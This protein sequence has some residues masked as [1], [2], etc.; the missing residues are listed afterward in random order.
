MSEKGDRQAGILFA[1][2][3][4]YQAKV[5]YQCS[6]PALAHIAQ[7][8]RALHGGSVSAMVV[9]YAYIAVSGKVLHKR[10]ISFLV[11]GHTVGDLENAFRLADRLKNCYRKLYTIC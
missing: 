6:S 5:F 9:D 11:L 7:V 10:I 8:L 4:L 3:F 1:G 2:P